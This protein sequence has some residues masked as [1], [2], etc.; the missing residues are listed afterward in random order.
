MNLC[1][2]LKNLLYEKTTVLKLL[3]VVKILLICLFSFIVFRLFWELIL[4]MSDILTDIRS[5]V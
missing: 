3:P 4:I 5:L 2:I 1:L